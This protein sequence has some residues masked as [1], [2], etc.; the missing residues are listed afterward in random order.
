MVVAT[1]ISTVE[2][3]QTHVVRDCYLDAT[4]VKLERRT[5]SFT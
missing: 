3:A 4:K 2:N 1:Y 5:Y